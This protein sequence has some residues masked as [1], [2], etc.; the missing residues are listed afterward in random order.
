[1]IKG[2]DT[3]KKIPLMALWMVAGLSTPH[4]QTAYDASGAP[5]LIAQGGGFV[6]NYREARAHYGLAV[7]PHKAMPKD[8]IVEA[9]FED[10]AGGPAWVAVRPFDGTPRPIILET[11]AVSGIRKG[12][13]YHVT[14]EVKRPDGTVVGAFSRTYQSDLDQAILPAVPLVI[15]PGYEP[16]PAA[17]PSLSP[18]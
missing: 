4:A 7:K 17:A 11:P 12:V 15:G 1:M 9:R 10:P 5:L 18:Q 2:R 13:D 3:L 6:F 8:A 16:N 14:V